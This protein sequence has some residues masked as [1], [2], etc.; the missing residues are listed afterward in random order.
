MDTKTSQSCQ[1]SDEIFF[2]K[3]K[4]LGIGVKFLTEYLDFDLLRHSYGSAQGRSM[5]KERQ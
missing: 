4:I 5:P 3:D 1:R 2:S